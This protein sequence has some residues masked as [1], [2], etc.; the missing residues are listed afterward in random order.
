MKNEPLISIVI[1]VYN[2]SNYVKE[3][4]QSCLDQ[5]YKNIE[6]IV[7]NDGSK[8][9]GKTAATVSEFGNKVH[10]FE[11]QNGGVASALNVAISHAKGQFV[12]WLSHDDLYDQNK[13]LRQIEKYNKTHDP[14][15]IIY[16]DF[17]VIDDGG[18]IV[19]YQ[20][21]PRVPPE[22]FRVALLM[23]SFLHGC[24]LLIPKEVFLDFGLFDEKLKTT[25]DYKFWFEIS[26]KYKF[27]GVEEYLVHSRW[28]SEQGVN[29]TKS[30]HIEECNRLYLWAPSVFDWSSLADYGF[31][32]WADF[33][34]QYSKRCMADGFKKAGRHYFFKGILSLGLSGLIKT[35]FRKLRV[36]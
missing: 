33:Y 1:P 3:A 25:Q 14:L 7:V 20:P 9:D 8:D 27:Y 4:I 28:H 29:K 13:I 32:N 10:Y 36:I 2:G 5:T 12:S 23:G 21:C 30:L 16:S 15:A 24:S 19:N 31:K 11:K 35:A 18:S 26:M 6:V 17:L 34:F 22:K